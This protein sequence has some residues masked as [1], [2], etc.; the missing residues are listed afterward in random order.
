[1]LGELVREVWHS[2]EVL[3]EYEVQ[4]R[5]GIGCVSDTLAWTG[6]GCSVEI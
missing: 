5:N 3:D 4:Y 1:M 6:F 2:G